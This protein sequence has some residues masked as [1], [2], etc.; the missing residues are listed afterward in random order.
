MCAYICP[1][2]LLVSCCSFGSY[3]LM[4]DM[5]KVSLKRGKGSPNAQKPC[6][7]CRVPVSVDL[8]MVLFRDSELRCHPEQYRADGMKVRGKWEARQCQED[9]ERTRER[10]RKSW[11]GIHYRSW[12]DTPSEIISWLLDILLLSFMM[13]HLQ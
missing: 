6:W 8:H 1:M 7:K 11:E 9:R 5:V 12:H 13:E 2:W 10:G 4:A 3:H